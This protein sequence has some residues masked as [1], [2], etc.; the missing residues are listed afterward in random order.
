MG[1]SKGACT[2]QN[3]MPRSFIARELKIEKRMR[4]NHI[5]Y[6]NI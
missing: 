4:F 3:S 6:L 5:P 1:Y 2:T